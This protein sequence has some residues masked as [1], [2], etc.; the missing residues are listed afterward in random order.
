MCVGI[1]ILNSDLNKLVREASSYTFSMY[2]RVNCLSSMQHFLDLVDTQIHNIIDEREHSLTNM[3]EMQ[4]GFN[5]N[6]NRY[7]SLVEV[8]QNEAKSE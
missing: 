2:T 1:R 6:L 4:K 7:K 8:E 3:R 5:N